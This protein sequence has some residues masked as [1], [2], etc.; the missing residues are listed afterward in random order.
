[1]QLLGKDL[2][3]PADIQIACSIFC[4]R[5]GQTLAPSNV[6]RIKKLIAASVREVVRTQYPQD[7][8]SLCHVYA[9]VGANLASITLQRTYKPVAGLAAIDAGA[10]KIICLADNLAFSNPAGGSYHC[11]IESCDLELHER[12]LLDF[13]IGHNRLYALKNGLPWSGAQPPRFLWGLFRE[14]VPNCEMQDLA[15]N[16]GKNKIWVRETESGLAWMEQHLAN[17]LNAYVNLTA[18]ALKAFRK[19]DRSGTPLSKSPFKYPSDLPA[20]AR[21]LVHH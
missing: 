13:T 5:N 1:M 14:L 19:L 7:H 10:G 3:I 8:C 9:V 2:L 20:A 12:E 21:S 15:P 16:F 17:H 18:L 6:S 11:W 4:T